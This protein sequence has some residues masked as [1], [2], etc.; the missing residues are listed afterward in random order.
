MHPKFPL[1][2]DRQFIVETNGILYV[3][4]AAA[5]GNMDRLGNTMSPV[6]PAAAA[7]AVAFRQ[8]A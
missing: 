7:K 4:L 3:I 1:L 2:P 6:V 5:N 8:R